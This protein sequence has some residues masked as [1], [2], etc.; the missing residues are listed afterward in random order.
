MVKPIALDTAGDAYTFVATS[1]RQ[2]RT[3][4]SSRRSVSIDEVIQIEDMG[5][6]IIYFDSESRRISDPVT[7]GPV[8]PQKPSLPVNFSIMQL[9]G[10][11]YGNFWV[12]GTRPA[13]KTTQWVGY[14]YYSSQMASFGSHIAISLLSDT[15]QLTGSYPPTNASA[16]V[17]NGV[18]VGNVGGTPN[19]CGFGTNHTPFYNMEVESYWNGGNKLYPATCSPAGF[20]DA[21]YYQ[22]G[23]QANTLGYV[24]YTVTGGWHGTHLAQTRPL[25]GHRAFQAI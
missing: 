2:G 19:G 3:T 7:R 1:D 23:I 21:T 25:I 10:V 14:T 22:V 18:I 15:S 8:P 17:G 5:F 13:G 12:A 4:L 6:N 16:I 11:V 24:A 9:S 20:A